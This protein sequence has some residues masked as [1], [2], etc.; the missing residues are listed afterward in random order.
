MH[1]L[2]AP[3]TENQ[4]EGERQRNKEEKRKEHPEIYQ[5]CIQRSCLHLRARQ[6]AK[7]QKQEQQQQKPRMTITINAENRLS[8]D[9]Q[10]IALGLC[11]VVSPYTICQLWS[12]FCL[13]F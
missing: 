4:I 7:H 10:S 11:R 2:D 1:V 6:N 5:A 9:I 8:N 12:A 3:D 13:R